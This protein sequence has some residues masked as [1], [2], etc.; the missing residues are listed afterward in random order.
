MGVVK[1]SPSE[2]TTKL[3]CRNLTP[4]VEYRLHS[5]WSSAIRVQ[6]SEFRVLGFEIE[7]EDSGS[8]VEKRGTRVQG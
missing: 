6:C 2:E 3:W 4:S 7:L 1:R 8:K 5:W